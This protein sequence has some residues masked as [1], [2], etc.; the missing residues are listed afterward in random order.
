MAKFPDMGLRL[1]QVAEF[2]GGVHDM[3]VETNK[4]PSEQF[5]LGLSIWVTVVI[6]GL[7]V[8]LGL[9]AE[10]QSIIFDGLFS[11]IDAAMSVLSLYVSRLLLREG[12][13]TFQYGFWHLEPLV[14]AFNGTVLLSI[15]VYAFINALK[16]FISGGRLVNFSSAATYSAIVCTVCFGMYLYERHAN[17]R[18]GSEFIR[19]DMKSFLMSGFI[20]IALFIGFGTAHVLGRMGYAHLEP[21][22]DPLILMVLVLGLLPIPV[23]IVAKA[24]KEVFLIA[25]PELHDH[26]RSVMEEMKQHYGFTGYRSYAAKS[27]RVYTVDINIVVPAD[28]RADINEFDAIREDIA[29][30]LS[31]YGSLE[32]WLSITFTANPD[33]L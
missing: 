33:W 32:K 5:V 15:C 29:K 11:V 7:G 22:A 24:L 20:T 8:I 14:A 27:G 6:A 31:E 25:P 21:Y 18:L 19:I 28:Y 17:K 10:S 16:G 9:L 4:G 12:S 1:A 30:R 23:G 3:A 13:R 26:V 2:T